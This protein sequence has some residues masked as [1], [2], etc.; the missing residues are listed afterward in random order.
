MADL[1]DNLAASDGESGLIPGNGKP[2]GRFGC[3]LCLKVV[4]IRICMEGDPSKIF[5]S[6][7]SLDL[8]DG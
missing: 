8:R 6:L 7:M 2:R 5:E 4:W 3:L 1:A